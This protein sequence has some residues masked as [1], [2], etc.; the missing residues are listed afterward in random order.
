MYLSEINK[1]TFT[2][3]TIDAHQVVNRINIDYIESNFGVKNVYCNFW[4][5]HLHLWIVLSTDVCVHPFWLFYVHYHASIR[6]IKEWHELTYVYIYIL[7]CLS[8]VYIYKIQFSIFP[9]RFESYPCFAQSSCPV[10]TV[11]SGCSWK[12]I[13]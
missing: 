6:Y 4:F 9:S 1:L 12:S 10:V 11:S 5:C 7:I 3:Y 13:G 2:K 8:H